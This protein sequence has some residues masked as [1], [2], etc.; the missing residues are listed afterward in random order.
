M[1]ASLITCAHVNAPLPRHLK[2]A[3]VILQ[4]GRNTQRGTARSLEASHS[5]FYVIDAITH[6]LDMSITRTWTITRVN[7]VMHPNASRLA[8][9]SQT[10]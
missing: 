9:H 2:D 5:R 6:H 8:I 7:V 4:A 3:V 1:H 10:C